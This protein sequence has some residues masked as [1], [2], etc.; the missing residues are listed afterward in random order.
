M[1]PP[2][3]V[4]VMDVMAKKEEVKEE[5]NDSTSE[6]PPSSSVLPLLSSPIPLVVKTDIVTK[7]GVE[8][9]NGEKTEKDDGN[10]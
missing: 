1:T 3:L 9:F 8:T 7:V 2:P 6:T 4:A 10:T 5:G